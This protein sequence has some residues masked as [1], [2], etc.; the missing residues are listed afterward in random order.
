M[1][2]PFKLPEE[3]YQLLVSLQ[4]KWNELTKRYGE[5]H[6]QKKGID[7]ELVLTDQALD[8]L[9]QERFNVVDQLQQKYGVGQVNLSTGTFIPE[10]YNP[11][12]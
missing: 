2:A 12:S 5:L 7:A 4:Q 1:T 3:D 11:E 9:D 8:Q 6:Y 10:S